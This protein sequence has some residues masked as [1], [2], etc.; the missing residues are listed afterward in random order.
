MPT[1]LGNGTCMLVQRAK[2]AAGLHGM[3][4]V[5][6]ETFHGIPT[7]LVNMTLFVIF[8]SAKQPRE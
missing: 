1:R 5:S 2:H 8:Q 6:D 7:D 4:R 3:S